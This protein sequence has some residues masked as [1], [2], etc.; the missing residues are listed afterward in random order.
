MLADEQKFTDEQRL[1]C[2]QGLA[3]LLVVQGEDKDR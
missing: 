2:E 3:E 1:A